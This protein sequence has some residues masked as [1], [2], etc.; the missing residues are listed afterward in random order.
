MD[1]DI[2][3]AGRQFEKQQH[4][5][6]DRGR[7]DVAICLSESVLDEAV[8][9]QAAVD[10]DEDRIAI[11]LLDFGL[12]DEAVEAHFA[13]FRRAG[14]IAV[15]IF[16]L[17]SP[18]RGLGQAYALERLHGCDRNQL[19]EGLLAEDLIDALAVSRD[20]RGYEHGVGGRM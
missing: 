2:D 5:R 1:V 9:N 18:R 14:R 6:V 10:E 16:L 19:I 20:G 7:N 15:L 11:Q 3:L 8:A 17:A 4:Y 12:R 13:G